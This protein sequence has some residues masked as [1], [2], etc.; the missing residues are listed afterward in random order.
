MKKKHGH[1]GLADRR[2]MIERVEAKRLDLPQD[3]RPTQ[4]GQPD[5]EPEQAPQFF[6]QRRAPVENLLR[7]G[8]LES[9][10]LAVILAGL[11]REKRPPP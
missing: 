9:E 1:V 7:P 6:R 11:A 2:A 4:P 10:Q 8:D 3:F 5:F